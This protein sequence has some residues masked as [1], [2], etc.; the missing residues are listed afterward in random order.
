MYLNVNMNMN[1]YVGMCFIVWVC[2]YVCGCVN[3]RV[4]G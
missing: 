1:V 4:F 2:G 3:V